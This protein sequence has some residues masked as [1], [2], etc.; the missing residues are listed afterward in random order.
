MNADY[1]KNRPITPE[2]DGKLLGLEEGVL[3][4][5]DAVRSQESRI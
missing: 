1:C 3:G 4:R 5:Y 2:K